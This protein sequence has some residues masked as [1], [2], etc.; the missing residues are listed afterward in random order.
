MPSTVLINNSGAPLFSI[1]EDT[2]VDTN[3]SGIKV[4]VGS[5]TGDAYD[6]NLNSGGQAILLHDCW[7]EQGSAS[8]DSVHFFTNRGVVWNCSF[9]SS[10]FSMA[11][12]AIHNQPDSVTTSWTSASTWG[13][14]DTTGQNNMYVE[15]NDFHAYLNSTD[16]DNNSRFVFRYNLMNNAGFGTHGAD[17]STFGQRFFEAYNNTGVYN[18]YSDGSTFPMNWWFFVRG[19]TYVIHDNNL[20]LLNSQDY[21]NKADVNMIVMN[22][23]RNAGPDPCWG[24]GTSGGADYHAPRQV[25]MG[26]VTGAGH[27][28]LGRTN[29]SVTYVGDSEPAYIWNNSRVPLG[30]IAIT[31][32]GF[33]FSNS[34]SGSTYDSS[35]NYIILN[36]DFFNGNTPKPGYTPYAY[37]HPLTQGL[38]Q[39][40]PPAP[41]SGLQA[42]VD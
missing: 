21:P 26:Y 9:D 15:T 14:L 34:C 10:P 38:G 23:Q 22:L 31:D 37:P 6:F 3:I 16:N 8:G 1:T 36:R 4:A 5:G 25:G 19:G 28:G 11:P 33:G 20:P 32:Y 7:V 18:G 40:A 29:D 39:G 35:V 2:S 24:A 30:N 17:T 27:D 12:L 41:P 13:V 42:I